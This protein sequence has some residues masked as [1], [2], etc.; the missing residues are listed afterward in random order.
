MVTGCFLAGSAGS[1]TLYSTDAPAFVSSAAF[2]AWPSGK[3]DDRS[4]AASHRSSTLEAF[5]PLSPLAR[6]AVQHQAAA[7]GQRQ[8]HGIAV[9]DAP[10]MALT[11]S[12]TRHASG[13]RA[14]RPASHPCDRNA[15]RDRPRPPRRGGAPDTGTPFALLQHRAVTRSLIPFAARGREPPAPACWFFP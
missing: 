8:R 1:T 3:V 14:P 12:R 10:A 2:R 15:A 13:H 11:V 7:L 6:V 5:T 9:A 4:V